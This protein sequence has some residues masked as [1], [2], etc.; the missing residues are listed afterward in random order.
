VN[1]KEGQIATLDA[2]VAEKNQR[3]S[4]LESELESLNAQL[5]EKNGRIESLEES[6][7]EKEER[8]NSIEQTVQGQSGASEFSDDVMSTARSVAETVREAVVVVGGT[9]TG[10]FVDDGYVITNSHVVDDMDDIT[11][12]T[13]NGEQFD[14][15]LLGRSDFFNQPYEDVA[16]LEYD[17]SPPASLSVGETASLSED[18][19]VMHV[20]HPFT[21]GEWVVSIGRV[22]NADAPSNRLLSS[23][24]SDGGNSGSPCVNLSGDVVGITTGSVS[25]G[26][27]GSKSSTPVPLEVKEQFDPQ[28]YTTHDTSSIIEKY[29]EQFG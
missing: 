18:Q 29:I 3:I 2:S 24:P 20:G 17:I 13:I 16:V 23:V 27:S 7:S 28:E 12:R 4:E 5:E 21:V 10:W 6:V 1:T 26:D 15:T 14:P 11:C 8:I 19:P 9:G 25:T 22:V